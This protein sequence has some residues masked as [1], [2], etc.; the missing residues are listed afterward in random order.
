MREKERE[1]GGE[2]GWE[3]PQGQAKGGAKYSP[4]TL[5]HLQCRGKMQMVVLF[6]CGGTHRFVGVEKGRGAARG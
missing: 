2:G 3:R 5:F 6:Y 1:R 4:V